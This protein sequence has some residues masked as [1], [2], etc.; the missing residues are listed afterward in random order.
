[1]T[2]PCLTTC[3][4]VA[5]CASSS[6]YVSAVWPCCWPSCCQYHS[7][8]FCKGA[9]CLQGEASCLLWCL[10]TVQQSKVLLSNS[11]RGMT[12]LPSSFTFGTHLWL[13][14]GR[15][16]TPRPS[17]TTACS[18]RYSAQCKAHGSLQRR[19]LSSLTAKLLPQQ[20]AT[21]G[22]SC[23]LPLLC[24]HLSPISCT[25]SPQHG[26]NSL[27]FCSSSSCSCNSSSSN[28]RRCFK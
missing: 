16:H 23:V 6:P 5:S 24:D 11:M 3:C 18:P 28:S 27:N 15:R 4:Q 8:H 26:S 20:C 9:S 1:M 13:S 19:I 10:Y 7:C 14:T 12:G 21:F 22:A 25:S 17:W 2:P